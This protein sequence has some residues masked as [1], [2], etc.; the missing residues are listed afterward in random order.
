[1]F[2]VG[3]PGWSGQRILQHR[4][5]AV[6]YG[7]HARGGLSMQT[8]YNEPEGHTAGSVMTRCLLS[9]V[10]RQGVYLEVACELQL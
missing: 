2:F 1:M 4:G 5:S 3:F 7:S 8:Y 9:I 6:S 10:A